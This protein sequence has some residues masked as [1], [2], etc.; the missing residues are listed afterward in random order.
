MALVKNTNSY[1]D[2]AEA[3]I[4]FGDRL[5]VAAWTDATDALKEQALV[6][7]TSMLDEQRWVGIAVSATQPLAFPR[8][9]TYF[10]PRIGT[11]VAFDSTATPDRVI[12][13]TYE[14]AYHLLNNDGL[15]DSISSVDSLKVGPIELNNIRAI[16]KKSLTVKNLITPMLVNGRSSLWWRA[17]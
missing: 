2:L 6:T 13:A 8:I 1:V 16:S 3:D 17:N 14:L 10:D 5:D 9:G 4:Y 7:A 12:K 15:L 11:E